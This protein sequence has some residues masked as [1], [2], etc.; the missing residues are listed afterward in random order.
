ME[1]GLTSQ[2][3]KNRVFVQP[4]ARVGWVRFLQDTPRNPNTSLPIHD[5]PG[6][7]FK[8]N[9]EDLDS[10][11]LWPE[12]DGV[13][14]LGSPL[15]SPSFIE[16]YLRGKRLKHAQLMDFIKSVAEAGYPKQATAMLT[17][18]AV[19]RLSHILKSI[20]KNQRTVL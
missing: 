3:V 20:P 4:S 13:N 10:A 2:A 7:S 5:I 9:P 14:I 17:G 6:G 1:A 15:G 8:L 12:L 19:P 16:S 11:R 18:A